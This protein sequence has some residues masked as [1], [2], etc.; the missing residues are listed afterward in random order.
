MART[1]IG[2][3]VSISDSKTA[4]VAVAERRRHKLY[5]KQYSITSRLPVHND[6]AKLGDRVRI[7]ETRPV[8]RHKAWRVEKVIKPNEASHD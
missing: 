3:I 5:D 6:S 1:L 2:L 4:V 7:A 8:S